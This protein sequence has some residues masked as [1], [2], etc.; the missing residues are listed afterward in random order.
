M[1]SDNLPLGREATEKCNASIGNVWRG[2]LKGQRFTMRADEYEARARTPLFANTEPARGLVCFF[3]DAR[4]LETP[5]RLDMF[6]R[7]HFH[8][9]SFLA[10]C[11]KQNEVSHGEVSA[12]CVNNS[13]QGRQ[14]R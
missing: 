1:P 12:K 14:K 5:K 13:M 6:I 7:F 10:S 11:W 8:F 2:T 4:S 3:F 9:A